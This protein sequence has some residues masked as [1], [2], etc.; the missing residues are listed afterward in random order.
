MGK[1]KQTVV[2]ALGLAVMTAAASVGAQAQ[3]SI[4]LVAN[5]GSIVDNGYTITLSGCGYSIPGGASGNCNASTS[6]SPLFG[7]QLQAV[8]NGRDVS[9]V[10][11]NSNGGPVFSFD[12]TGT[13]NQTADIS[14]TVTM[15][16]NAGTSMKLTSISAAVQGTS[17]SSGTPYSQISIGGTVQWTGGGGGSAGLSSNATTGVVGPITFSPSATVILTEDLDLTAPP[18]TTLALNGN[19]TKAPEPATLAILGPAILG[20]VKAR[21]LRKRQCC[22]SV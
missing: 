5:G 9:F 7:D 17:S 6:G 3:T 19:P 16:Q 21:K 8:S 20:L 1:F 2:A 15:T 13:S 11:V 18:G 10:L 22:A 14:Y 12:N 4:S